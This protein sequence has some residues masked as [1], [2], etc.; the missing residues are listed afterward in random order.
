MIGENLNYIIFLKLN[1]WKKIK[2]K[3]NIIYN[4]ERHWKQTNKDRIFDIIQRVKSMGY[5]L[6]MKNHTVYSTSVHVSLM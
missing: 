1:Q 2:A 5:Y 3:Y 4:I 6:V